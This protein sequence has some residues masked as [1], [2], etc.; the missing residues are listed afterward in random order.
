MQTTADRPAA[1]SNVHDVGRLYLEFSR[2]LEVLVRDDVR[3]C[4]AVIEDACQLAWAQLVR[5]R[6][7]VALESARHWLTKTAVREAIRL[8]RYDQRECSLDLLLAE[9]VRD[10]CRSAAGEQDEVL[11][12]RERLLD[13]RCLTRRQQ[14]MVWL[15]ALGLS[16]DEMASHEACTFRTVERQLGQARERLRVLG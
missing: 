4:D 8:I 13:V 10:P 16:Y 11:A 6:H 12:Q 3:A 15:K 9:G 14:R 1:L 5:Y 2:S 7:R